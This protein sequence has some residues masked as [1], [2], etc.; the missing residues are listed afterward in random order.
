MAEAESRR[1]FE[2]P[3]VLVEPGSKLGVGRRMLRRR[4]FGEELH[5]LR[6]SAPHDLVVLVEPEREAFA[7][8]NLVL[9]IVLDQPAELLL[10]RP[11]APLRR[12]DR[13]QAR[14]PI[15]AQHDLAR[16]RRRGCRLRLLSRGRRRC[17]RREIVVEKEQRRADQN[18][19]SQR[20]TQ[21]SRQPHPLP[22]QSLLCRDAGLRRS[23]EVIGDGKLRR[24]VADQVRPYDR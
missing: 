20:L 22:T 6:H 14:E 13:R 5:L 3:L 1:L 24:R 16:G 4:V 9:H 11:A 23:L 12:K 21:Q 19:L 15:E 17:C 18:E 10:C 8:K 2:Q 7:I